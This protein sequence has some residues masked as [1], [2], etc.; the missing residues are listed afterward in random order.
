MKFNLIMLPQT[1]MRITLSA[2]FVFITH[3]FTYCQHVLSGQVIDHVTNTAINAATIIFI[4]DEEEVHTLTNA[5]GEFILKTQAEVGRI[6]IS[7]IGYET[8]RLD[9]FKPNDLLIYS[10]TPVTVLLE[11]VQIS[12]KIDGRKFVE[13]AFEKIIQS[14]VRE[15]GKAFY[16]QI[17][18]TNDTINEIFEVFG[19]L[20]FSPDGV[21]KY[22][23]TNARFGQL[24]GYF[25]MTNMFY[26]NARLTGIEKTSQDLLILGSKQLGLYDF[27]VEE[28]FEKDQ[29]II[30][31]I[32]Y[33]PK[34]NQAGFSGTLYIDSLHSHIIK[35]TSKSS[36]E[37]ALDLPK[38]FDIHSSM[39]QID[40]DY[41]WS[42][43]N[44]YRISHSEGKLTIVGKN[45][46]RPMDVHIT[47][48]LINYD[49]LDSKAA[50]R[51][52]ALKLN[53]DD[54]KEI[55]KLKYNADFWRDNPVIKRTP[56]EEEI[57]KYFDDKNLMGNYFESP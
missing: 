13:K 57:I 17:T 54:F 45:Q 50:N 8:I 16:R 9:I 18:H 21:E 34:D 52:K 46:D 7:H 19:D 30:Y 49:K 25:S 53:R 10:L 48:K 47:S 32:S 55:R 43:E 36:F 11:E 12:A 51:L 42:D 28:V 44:T 14:Q 29:D 26:I 5:Q 40:T 3:S 22:K 41:H 37:N 56:L 2:I 1:K 31:K 6:H 27:I 15:F 38:S 23:F 4:S 20:Q 39:L 24:P 33:T 35:K